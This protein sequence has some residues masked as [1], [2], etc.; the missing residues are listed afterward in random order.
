MD[1]ENFRKEYDKYM[2]WGTD[3]DLFKLDSP[4]MSDP[5]PGAANDDVLFLGDYKKS[6]KVNSH[7]LHT[8]ITGSN[9]YD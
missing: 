2:N 5:L 9:R 8:R 7:T 3:R 1:Y 6:D 4:Y